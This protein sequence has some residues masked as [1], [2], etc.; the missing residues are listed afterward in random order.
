MS[1]NNPIGDH[2]KDPYEPYR[3]HADAIGRSKRDSGDG[4]EPPDKKNHLLVQI[5]DLLRKAIDF[6]LRMTEQGDSKEA[7]THVLENLI[8][9]KSFFEILKRE[10]RSQDI[11]FL[12][13]LSEVWQQVL[14]D[15]LR[16]KR[17]SP[18]AIPFRNFLRTIQQYPPGEEHSFAYYLTEYTGQTWLPFPYMD[19]IQ[20]IHRE[21]QADPVSSALALWVQQIDGLLEIL[22]RE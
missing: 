7:E 2:P 19:L 8:L 9:I 3:I 22:T 15:S 6:V 12:N 14:E 11:A 16:F 13:R 21:Y 10:D 17:H 20:T 1:A 5:L 4:G 18:V